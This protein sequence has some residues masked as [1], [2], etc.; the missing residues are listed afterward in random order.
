MYTTGSNISCWREAL[1]PLVSQSL[2]QLT[3][4]QRDQLRS[5]SIDKDT[6][7]L[8]KTLCVDMIALMTSVICDTYEGNAQ[9]SRASTHQDQDTAGSDPQMC[10][11]I[12]NTFI[13]QSS[14]PSEIRCQSMEEVAR[15]VKLEIEERTMLSLERV[16]SD[17]GSRCGRTNK[18][19][20]SKMFKFR[21]KTIV[22]HV[23]QVL[24]RYV[25]WS[26]SPSIKHSSETSAVE[27]SATR[28]SSSSDV[29]TSS[30]ADYSTSLAESVSLDMSFKDSDEEPQRTLV[31]PLNTEECG[32]G[33]ACSHMGP[34]SSVEPGHSEV[35]ISDDSNPH[36]MTIWMPYQAVTV[37]VASPQEDGGED[38]AC[39]DD[40]SDVWS[41][42]EES[43]SSDDVTPVHNL[44]PVIARWFVDDDP[45]VDEE[46]LLDNVM[47]VHNIEPAIKWF[48]D[49]VTSFTDKSLVD[50]V[51]PVYELIRVNDELLVKDE[52]P[53]HDV[54]AIVS[55]WCVEDE[56][57]VNDEALGFSLSLGPFSF[58]DL[59]RVNDVTSVI[60]KMLVNDVAPVEDLTRVNDVTLDDK[61]S[62]E[63]KS[64][65]GNVVTVPT[66]ETDTIQGWE[67]A[68]YKILVMMLIESVTKKTQPF[69]LKHKPEII[70]ALTQKLQ[71]AM[72]GC[73]VS[74][75]PTER[76]CKKITKAVKKDLTK[77]WENKNMVANYLLTGEDH[78]K[79]IIVDTMKRQLTAPK[80]KSFFSRICSFFGR[81]K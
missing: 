32:N 72:A 35:Q 79:Q 42:V 68:D 6:R 77:Q 1:L 19:L 12:V 46:L 24:M 40:W 63:D 4:R 65:S 41:D 47:P 36:G 67:T 76:H 69:M 29:E 75:K 71:A 15:L 80:K 5:G 59:T 48:V 9:A 51:T 57:L 44:T 28:G 73:D 3:A 74:V 23:V 60:D 21:L 27:A 18:P 43:E 8:I 61:S 16:A 45:L 2:R 26:A 70:A 78:A 20:V 7:K 30:S 11:T 81:K 39:T 52:L 33:L 55:K 31:I 49:D 34:D 37:V 56:V 13:S 17:N 64:E 50:E 14:L 25:C 22:R 54:T 10:D 53:V 38:T 62:Q 66:A 58:E